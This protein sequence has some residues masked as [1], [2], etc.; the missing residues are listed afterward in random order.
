VAAVIDLFSRRAVGWSMSAEM[1]AQLV[2]DA[3]VM[4]IWYSAAIWMRTARQ[5]G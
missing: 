4:A 2:T 5:S 3:L 1:T